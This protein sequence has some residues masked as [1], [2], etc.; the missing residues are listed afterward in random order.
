MVSNLIGM[1]PQSIVFPKK[2][3]FDCSR[4]FVMKVL[5]QIFPPNLKMVFDEIFHECHG[6]RTYTFRG[7]I[8]T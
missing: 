1:K 3:C 4:I 7:M 2:R 6:C 8:Y 5:H